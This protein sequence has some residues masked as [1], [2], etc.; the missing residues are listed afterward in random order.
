MANNNQGNNSNNHGNDNRDNG[1]NGNGNDDGFFSGIGRAISG[2]RNAIAD[3]I[4]TEADI[5]DTHDRNDHN[6][7]YSGGHDNNRNS[8][9]GINFRD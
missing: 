2:T 1:N 5:V 3:F 4:H 9:A 7:N 8:N 6:G